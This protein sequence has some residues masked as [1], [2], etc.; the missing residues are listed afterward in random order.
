VIRDPA[1]RRP[2]Q[3]MR[4]RVPKEAVIVGLVAATIYAAAG[5]YLT[6]HLL[7]VP[8]DSAFRLLHADFVWH[9]DP[10]KLAA[11]GFVW[12]PVMTLSLLPW[13]LPT[14]LVTSLAAIPLSSAVV[15]GLPL[16]RLSHIFKHFGV[17]RA[18]RLALVA[19]FGL[20]PLFFHYA[21]NGMSEGLVL[22]LLTASLAQ[23]LRW[24][25]TRYTHHLAFCGTAMALAVL[26]RYDVAPC[27]VLLFAATAA[28][29]YAER[30]SAARAEGALLL[31]AAPMAYGVGL[32][33]MFNALI[34]GA[35]LYFI[36]HEVHER[37]VVETGRS[38]AQGGAGGATT[39]VTGL[40]HSLLTLNWELFAPTLVAFAALTLFAARR[41]NGVAALLAV[42]L[43]VNPVTTALTV[44]TS[45]LSLLQLRFNMRSM[46]FAMV[47][48][49][50]LVAAVPRRRRSAAAML[51]AL[52]VLAA[53]PLTW[54][55]MATWPYTFAERDFVRAVQTGHVQDTIGVRRN[56][57]LARWIQANVH[58][59]RS[60][61]VDDAQTFGAILLTGDPRVFFDRADLGDDRWTEAARDPAAHGVRYLLVP[62][63]QGVIH[64][65]LLSIYPTAASGGVS[66]LRP[67]LRNAGSVLLRV[68]PAAELAP[69]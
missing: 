48:I 57:P 67:V 47:G 30:A 23:W 49:G 28:D 63:K 18:G 7:V 4:S 22:L 20:N 52:G 44:A 14:P 58:D 15:A 59:S 9:N 29:L 41:R 21:T 33:A 8:Y 2:E 25:E 53:V 16:A 69:H 27:A 54:H 13:A 32:W 17:P 62:A 51:A 35:P 55:A 3:R 11:I 37:F 12:P 10:A 45:D 68:V 6:L 66:F 64:D 39:S 50:W 5:I 56:R 43:L 61:L 42:A 60:I 19:A 34:V 46:P 24:H 1:K 31:Y 36:R 65:K 38:A 26:T 40:A